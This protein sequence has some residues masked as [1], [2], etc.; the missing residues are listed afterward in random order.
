MNFREEFWQ[1]LSAIE[2]SRDLPTSEATALLNEIEERLRPHLPESV[3]KYRACSSRNFDALARNVIYAVPASYMNDPF[4]GLVYVDIEKIINDI[5]YG[6]SR[7]FLEYV[8]E[9]GKLPDAMTDF[10]TKESY[11][12]LLKALTCLT[13][14]EIEEK[15]KINK[16]NFPSLISGVKSLV[17]NLLMVLQKTT[18]ISSFASDYKE[19]SMW[20]YYAENHTGYAVEY[21]VNGTRFD[22][23]AYCPKRYKDCKENKVRAH[24]YPIVYLDNRYDA[25]ANMDYTLGVDALRSGGIEV[26]QGYPDMMFFD[27]C[28]LIKG[29]QWEPENEWR[30]V[31]Y[32]EPSIDDHAPV[33]IYVN[34]PKAIYYGARIAEENY[35]LLHSIVEKLR[36][37]GADIKE[38]KMY[39]NPYSRDF[40]LKCQEIVIEKSTN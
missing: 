15:E 31:C 10:L 38:Y 16:E 24:L 17:D 34:P 35:R 8:K 40:N 26:K 21:A 14:A 1:A 33:P 23:C 37:A 25:T 22:K 39:L 19:S 30:L 13:E 20:A 9:Y 12:E 6:Q 29:K 7:E 5:K 4:D 27:K 36:S 32:Q 28:C 11:D 2:I 18:L 3:F